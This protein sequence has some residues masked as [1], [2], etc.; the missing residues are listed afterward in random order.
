MNIRTIDIE[1]INFFHR[2][3][4]PIARFGLFVVFFYFGLLKVIGLSPASG[5]VQQLF[6][7]TISFISF[8]SFI[9]LFGLFE[10]LIGI[11]FIIPGFERV[12]IPMLFLHMMMTFMPLFVLP[13]M[14]WS[15]FLVPTLE[16]Q[17]IIKNLVII[18]AA[19]AIAA[20][21]HPLSKSR[22]G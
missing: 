1:L 21:L 13:E 5:L 18:A 9:V 7:Q 15:R 2:I 8:N 3:S 17:Y 22:F 20:H 19:I 12:V 6:E 4:L 10:C 16:G 11:F 14:T